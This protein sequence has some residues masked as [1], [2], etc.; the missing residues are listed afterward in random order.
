MGMAGLVA[1]AKEFLHAHSL[2]W[3][4]VTSSSVL[5]PVSKLG[6]LKNRSS[7][8][9]PLSDAEKEE[10]GMDRDAQNAVD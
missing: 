6:P 3:L 2:N 1:I 7:S 5:Q 4:A 10:N 8:R 9:P